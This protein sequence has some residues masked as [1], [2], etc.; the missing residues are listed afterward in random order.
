MILN[1]PDVYQW[2]LSGRRQ[3]IKTTYLFLN[4]K[5]TSR[6]IPRCLTLKNAHNAENCTCVQMLI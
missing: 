3:E 5:T 1:I 6:I 2:L 4:M